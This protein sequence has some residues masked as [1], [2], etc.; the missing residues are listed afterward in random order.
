MKPERCELLVTSWHGQI[1]AGEIVLQ[2]G[3][4]RCFANKGYETLMKSVRSECT[5]VGKVFDPTK[6]PKGWFNSLPLA[7]SG[8]LLRAWMVRGKCRPVPE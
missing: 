3:K 7:Y 8:I 4:L 2:N 6:D 5:Y 1:V